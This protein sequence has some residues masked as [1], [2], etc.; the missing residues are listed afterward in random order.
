MRQGRVMRCD[1]SAIHVE[2]FATGNLPAGALDELER[3]ATHL[4]RRDGRRRYVMLW[5]EGPSIE[6]VDYEETGEGPMVLS[7]IDCV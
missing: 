7:S 2:R 5:P 3:E 1:H 4:T 6:E